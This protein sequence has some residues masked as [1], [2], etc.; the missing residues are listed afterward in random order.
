MT[1]KKECYAP[2]FKRNYK[3]NN[4][5]PINRCVEFNQIASS[6]NDPKMTKAMR[7]SQYVNAGSGMKNTM[8]ISYTDYVARFGPLPESFLTPTL[9]NPLFQTSYR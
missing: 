7:Y 5:L 4:F 2:M 8:T 9:T 6:G 1:D 3:T